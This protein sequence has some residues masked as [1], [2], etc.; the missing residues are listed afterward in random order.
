MEKKISE[1]D[2][3]TVTLT[4]KIRSVPN[5]MSGADVAEATLIRPFEMRL[6]L[7]LFI[8]YWITYLIGNNALFSLMS[9]CGPISLSAILLWS[10]FRIAQE[11]HPAIWTPLFWFRLACAVYFGFGA[12]VLQI[13]NT[14]TVSWLNE[15]YD[16]TE[17]L[18]YKVNVIYISGI[19]ATLLFS[20]FFLTYFKKIKRNEKKGVTKIRNEQNIV[21]FGWIYLISGGILRYA[22]VVPYEMGLFNFTLPGILLALANIYYAGIYL[23]SRA[24]MSVKKSYFNIIIIIIIIDLFVSVASFS[25]TDLIKILI[26]SFLGV[27]S[28]R[29][30]KKLLIGCAGIVY[31]AYAAFGPLV[32]YGREEIYFRYGEIR[33]AGISERLDISLEW[34]AGDTNIA[35]G[36]RQASLYRTSY[37]NVNA[38]VVDRY[39]TGQPGATFVNAAAVFVPRMIWPDKPIISN[40]GAELNELVTGSDRSQLGVGHFAE[41]Y[42]NFGWWGIVPMMA[43]LA[44]ILTIYSRFSIGVMVRGEWLFFP[45]VLLGV[46]IG[47][48]VDGHFVVDTLGPAWTALIM[49]IP[50]WPLRG[51]SERVTARRYAPMVTN[52]YSAH[53]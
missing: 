17:R 10:C 36:S 39:D 18:N 37:V 45:L 23:L 33:G 22:F 48:R 52:T 16:L 25:K 15:T 28:N 24:S 29:A 46:T 21:Y 9:I 43:V 3:L 42:W 34:L 8:L 31:L 35:E 30:S 20:H 2:R 50:L 14:E 1:L 5:A 49:A 53:T 51:I 47:L 40:L 44:F 27:V 38:F 12:L 19:F 13:A 7:L 32:T 6:L 26:F 41:A 4:Q 11:S